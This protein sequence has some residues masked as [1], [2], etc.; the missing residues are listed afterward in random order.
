[1]SDPVTRLNTALEGR[2]VIERKLGEGGMATVYLAKD[3]KH[4]REVALKILKPELAAV[5][6]SERFLAEIQVTA[7]LTHPHILPLHDSGEADGFLYYVMPY[8]E[9]ETLRERIDRERQ[10]PVDEALGIATAVANAL[11]T[12]HEQGVV[13]RDIKPGNILLSRGEPLVADFGIALAVS[14]GGGG[15]LTETGLSMGT[16][17]YMSPEQATGDQIVGPASDTFALACVLYE[18]L[19]G[20]PPYPGNT[21]QAVLGKIIQG[22]PVSATTI[23]Q[24]VPTNVD[25]AINKAL[26]TLPADRFTSAQDFAR[27]LANPGFTHGETVAVGAGVAG[28]RWNAL[29]LAL[30]VTTLTL[31]ALAGWSLRRPEPPRPVARFVSPFLPGQ[32]PIQSAS[33]TFSLSADGSALVYRGPDGRL[34]VR[35][36]N[37]PGAS[38]IP[39][40][41][42]AVLPALSPDGAGLAFSQG[43][44]VRVLAFAGGSPRSLMEGRAPFWGGDGY[45]YATVPEGTARVPVGGGS[46]EAVTRLAEGHRQHVVYDVLPGGRGALVDVQFLDGAQGEEVQAVDLRTGSMTPLVQGGEGYYANTGHL[47]FEAT[48][49]ND[50][51]AVTFDPRSMETSGDV[52]TVLEERVT[53]A[54]LSR[55]G[56]LVY[57]RIAPGGERAEFVWATRSGQT[58][59]VEAGWTFSSDDE[60]SGWRLSP[61]DRRIAYVADD[62]EPGNRDVWVKELPG[63]PSSRLT[64][65]E[66]SEWAPRWASG[67]ET[68]TFRGPSARIY[69]TRADGIGAPEVLVP[70]GNVAEAFWSP[71]GEWL[72]IRRGGGGAAQ[73]LRGIQAIRPGSDGVALQLIDGSESEVQPDL[74][75]DG[76]WLAYASNES[77]RYEVYV[78]PFPD[79][80]AGKWQVST[81]GGI[82]PMWAHNGR[83]LF[84]VSPRD[85]EM[86]VAGYEATS[87]FRVVGREALFQLPGD[88]LG[89]TARSATNYDV[90]SDDQRF[91]WAR[92]LGESSGA[93][94]RRFVLVQNW[95]EE[96]KERAPN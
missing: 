8:I 10:L 61:D 55:S 72:V 49:T 46:P 91:L 23:R 69:S 33:G 83:E 35:R 22:L 18:M 57:T 36:W 63:G 14:A 45:I 80:D 7:N 62:A 95:T 73:G 76:R 34:W 81:E 4:N 48:E 26:E 21:A 74:S 6:G 68:I 77:G 16:P 92:R 24:S 58:E 90:S 20:E 79:V 38:P 71:D 89:L 30:A 54:R 31:G 47:I 41:E 82:Q 43:T 29:T 32:E 88:F 52:V 64:D 70:E 66:G 12:A 94:S 2:Y 19:V 96:L 67:G 5:V 93:R 15:R 13:H 53:G 11:Q 87:D 40:T 28:G 27:A 1:M 44:D 25:A 60:G 9:G 50:L 86:W 56:T 84:F 3:L 65:G 17:F 39:G 51:M 42:G 85:E 37:D 59:P 78:R 75:P